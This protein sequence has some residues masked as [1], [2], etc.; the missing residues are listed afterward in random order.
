MQELA[1]PNAEHVKVWNEILVPK[2]RRYRHVLVGGFSGHSDAAL[3]EFPPGRGQRVLDIGCGFGETSLELATRVGPDGY[4]LGID[5][6]DAFIETGRADA[7][8]AGL[9]NLRF[10]VADAQVARFDTDFD[11]CFARFGTMFFQNPVAALRN[12]RRALKPQGRLMMIVWRGIDDNPWLGLPKGIAQAHLPPPP[13]EAPNCGPGPFSMADQ[14]TV[15]QM[16]TAA[17]FEDPG[18][19]RT[20]T[21]ACI[22]ATPQAAV[23]FQLSLGPAGEIV[24]E[25]GEAGERKRAIIEAEVVALLQ[26]HTNER[27]VV[28]GSSSW[29]VTARN[30]G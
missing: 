1:T 16:L 18:F 9:H 25:A 19:M 22:G 21:Q 7:G 12:L 2:F 8:R 5:C 24:R 23:E 20:D 14:Q 6:C 4:V 29:C 17:G 13:D 30:P 15:T 26:T 27:G 11:L 3:A 28:I 10:E